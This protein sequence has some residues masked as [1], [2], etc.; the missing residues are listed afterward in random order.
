MMSFARWLALL[1]LA[2][3]VTDS[4]RGQTDSTS[5]PVDEGSTPLALLLVEAVAFG[6]GAAARSETGARVIGGIQGTAGL[7]MLGIAAFSDRG[8]GWP[9]FTVP[10]GL[11]LCALSYYNFTSASSARRDD[12]FWTNVLG[13]NAT[14]LA[15][16]ISS[17]L[18]RNEHVSVRGGPS[19][20]IGTVR[21]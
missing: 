15:G 11:G 16:L 19:G 10:Y 9:E 2:M 17:R 14:V 21:F 3:A 1:A 13:F 5:R 7:A 12:R 20:L 18:L 8:G 6:S 4:A